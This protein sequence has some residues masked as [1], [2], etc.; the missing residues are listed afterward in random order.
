MLSEDI[1]C[2]CFSVY[3]EDWY[4]V[5]LAWTRK[6]QGGICYDSTHHLE[7]FKGLWCAPQGVDNYIYKKYR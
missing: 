1:Y 3:D 7:D 5:P 4:R 2:Q 6:V